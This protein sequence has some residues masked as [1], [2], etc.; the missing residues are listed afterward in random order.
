[1]IEEVCRACNNW[2]A[3][4]TDIKYGRYEIKNGKIVLPNILP[5]QYFRIEGSAL[6]DGVYEMSGYENTVKGLKDEVFDGA[7]WAMRVP[8]AFIAL[9]TRIKE[10]SES[11]AASPSG[12]RSE[13]FGG[14]SYTKGSVDENSWKKV[15]AN[16]LNKWRKL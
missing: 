5:G 9:C 7:V 14:Y 15:F 6:N 12:Y 11:D 10:Y 3:R 16:D 13:S 1:M 8:P 4:K 2:F